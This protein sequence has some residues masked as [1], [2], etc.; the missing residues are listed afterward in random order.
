MKADTSCDILL[1]H[2][3]APLIESVIVNLTVS[4]RVNYTYL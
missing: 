2:F 4:G 1:R 3:N